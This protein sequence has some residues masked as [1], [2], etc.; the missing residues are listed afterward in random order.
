MIIIHE[1]LPV[2]GTPEFETWLKAWHAEHNSPAAIAQRGHENMRYRLTP[3]G[4]DYLKTLEASQADET[5]LP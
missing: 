2:L 3:A 5:V 4:A 1:G